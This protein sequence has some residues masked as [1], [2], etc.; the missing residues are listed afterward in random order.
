MVGKAGGKIHEVLR[1]GIIEK[2]VEG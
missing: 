2:L 1:R